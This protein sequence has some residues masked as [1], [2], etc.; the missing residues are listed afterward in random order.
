[1]FVKALHSRGKLDISSQ[2]TYQN[3]GERFFFRAALSPGQVIEIPD[4]YRI[5]KNIDWAVKTGKLQILSYN[6]DDDG[7]LVVNAELRKPYSSIKLNDL[8]VT[9]IPETNYSSSGMKILLKAHDEQNFGDTCFINSLGE[10]QIGNAAVIA[11]ASTI[12]MCVDRHI[13]ANESGNYILNGIVRNDDWLWNVGGLIFLT[14]T[15]TTGNTLSQIAPS[16]TDN[17]VQ[18][19]G[20]ATHTNRMYFNP[21]LVQV[22]HK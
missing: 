15:G 21:S 2:Q 12:V 20:V 4:E 9:A 6:N 19:I 7:S 22:E 5:L 13:N 14:I 16:A 18:I 17:S 3:R 10:T 8:D 11:T 1:M